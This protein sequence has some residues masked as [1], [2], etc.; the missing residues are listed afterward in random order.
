[1]DKDRAYPRTWG[2]L[3]VTSSQSVMSAVCTCE[4]HSC[5]VVSYSYGYRPCK[6]SVSTKQQLDFYTAAVGLSEP[7]TAV[8]GNGIPLVGCVARVLA[9]R[10]VCPSLEIAVASRIEPSFRK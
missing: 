5:L 8:E 4:P 3:A 2:V 10:A 6:A 9:P 1:M 7:A